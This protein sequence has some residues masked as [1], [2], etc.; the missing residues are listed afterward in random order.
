MSNQADIYLAKAKIA[1][2]ID[3]IIEKEELT[4]EDVKTMAKILY[5]RVK[6][7]EE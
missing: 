1:T 2:L 3:E 5:A 6:H 4:K 7:S